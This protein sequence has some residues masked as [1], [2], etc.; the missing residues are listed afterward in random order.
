MRKSEPIAIS[1][2]FARKDQ[3]GNYTYSA[4]IYQNILRYSVVLK[5]DTSEN[6]RLSFTLWEITDWLTANEEGNIDKPNK[7]RIEN[8]Q[9]TIR[10][11]LQNLVQLKLIR[12]AGHKPMA[13]GTGTI[14]TYQF[15]EFGDLFALTTKSFDSK[16]WQEFH[17]ICDEIYNLF[18]TIFRI[19]EDSTSTT[20][21]YSKFFERCKEKQVFEYIVMLLR[22]TLAHGTKNIPEVEDLFR[23]VFIFGFK[24][25]ELRNYLNR[26]FDETIDSLDFETKK[27]VLYSLKLDIESKMRESVKD[28]DGFE[29]E[30]YRVRGFADTVALEGYCFMCNHFLPVGIELLDY[31][32]WDRDPI[33]GNLTANCPI[34]GV[35]S[36]L[37]IADVL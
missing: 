4:S 7:Q 27:L 29:K 9:E 28:L 31:R 24:D 10:T 32:K 14:T 22:D 11:K 18:S 23:R 8:K 12:I 26:L 6:K 2:I 34:C 35:S 30:R 15:T 5:K 16:T 36:S 19:E 1:S 25:K 3:D 13:K 37:Q 21:F 17:H 20:I 33:L